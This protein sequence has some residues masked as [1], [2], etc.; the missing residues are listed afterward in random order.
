MI[1][2]LLTRNNPLIDPHLEIWEWQVP[3]YLFLGGLCAGLLILS[4]LLV[5]LKRE[6]D[7]PFST[8]WGALLAPAFL[9][10]G[11]ACLFWDLSS[12]L[13]VFRFYTAFKP[14]SALSWG[15]WLL[16]LVYPANLLFLVMLWKLPDFV[17]QKITGW[18]DKLRAVVLTYKTPLAVIN[19]A[20]GLGVG[21][22]TGVF[23][24]SLVAIR[25]WNSALM[26]PL[27]LISGLST[28]AALA[29]L[30]ERGHR[31]KHQLGAADSGLILV[32]LALLLLLVIDL[33]AGCG[34]NRCAAQFLLTD[35][36]AHI[37][38]IGLVGLGLLVPLVLEVFNNF[39]GNVRAFWVAP[40]L[41]LS[42]GLILRFLMVITGQEVICTLA[43]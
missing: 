5:L 17:P 41:V 8:K 23:L 27:F 24:S 15:A 37:F 22:Y 30:F 9:S 32:E 26:G 7:F 39:T 35:G 19:L 18:Y 36:V 16:V 10:L 33:L 4:A 42:G 38:W 21:I 29:V 31:E 25:L 2:K 3:L 28:A 1:E 14:M 43:F 12:K 34:G 13:H 11:M 40:L 20:L 6:Q